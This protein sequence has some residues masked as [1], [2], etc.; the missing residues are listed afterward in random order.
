MNL[1][2]IQKIG[3][4]IG[5]LGFLAT[6]GTQLTDIFA[7]LGSIAPLIVKEIVSLSGFVSGILG[8]VLAFITGQANAVKAV[9]AMPGVESIVVNKNA[10]QTLAQLAVDPTQTKIDIAPGATAAVTQTAKGA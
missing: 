8:V 4:A 3:L 2:L 7:P 6:A 9:Q 1:T 5:V 10:S